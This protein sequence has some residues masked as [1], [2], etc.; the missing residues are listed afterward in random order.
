MRGHE[1]LSSI[2]WSG[3]VHP[4]TI[5]SIEAAILDLDRKVHGTNKPVHQWTEVH[6]RLTHFIARN[7]GSYRKA[8]GAL[9]VSKSF[10]YDM[11]CGTRPYTDAVLARLGLQRTTKQ[12]F[13]PVD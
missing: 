4:E 8:A 10:L 7:G 5:A 6:R 2:A 13:T 1:I 12:I 11:H 3:D 9:G